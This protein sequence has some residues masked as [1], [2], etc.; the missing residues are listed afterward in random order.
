MLLAKWY[1]KFKMKKNIKIL[2]ITN[3]IPSYRLPLYE[4]L[5]ERFDLFIAHF[6]EVVNSN[7]FEEI[8]L[9]RHNF[10][11]FFYFKNK[12]DFK[13]FNV[14]IIWGNL[15]MFNIYRLV[16]KYKRKYKLILF[17]PGVSSSYSQKYD[18]NW[19]FSFVTKI[20]LKKSNAGIF[21]DNYPVIKYRALGVNPNKLFAAFNTVFVKKEKLH[22]PTL[23]KSFLFIGTLYKEK[24]LMILLEAYRNL[25][26]KKKLVLPIL[27]IVG[28][29]PELNYL[30]NWVLTNGLSNFIFFKGQLSQ[31]ESLKDLFKTAL[32]CISPLQAG[33]SVQRAHA[34]GVPFLTCKFPITGGEDSAI[35][36]DVTG[37]F[38][39]GSV[40]GLENE[41]IRIL[42]FEGLKNCYQ[43]CYHFY[44][45]FRT[46]QIW[47]D[48]FQ[49]AIDY[50][51]ED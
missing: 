46:P 41:I 30:K 24:G 36:Q 39:D 15:R 1:Q 25:I 17:G 9:D 44:W 34:Y 2:F 51:L 42:K 16:F 18:T 45:N 31:D 49:K 38:F 21:Y 33:L 28:D 47:V 20:L 32:V 13:K 48:Q 11:P 14:I 7:K 29:G 12:L 22:E 37:F 43:K 35:I 40:N 8:K 27:N 3:K 5:G 4:L 19:V 6:G 10:G 26:F 50:S 23:R